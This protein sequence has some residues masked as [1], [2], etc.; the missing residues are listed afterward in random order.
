M[1]REEGV[2]SAK[3][4]WRWGHGRA[5]APTCGGGGGGKCEVSPWGAL[6]CGYC[7]AAHLR[8]PS[9]FVYFIFFGLETLT[10]SFARALE[11]LYPAHEACL[12]KPTGDPTAPSPLS[13]MLIPKVSGLCTFLQIKS[14]TVS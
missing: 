5:E 6:G 12:G 13:C 1:W 9:D 10:L 11:L 7:H 2:E 8:L 14:P 4:E 3:S